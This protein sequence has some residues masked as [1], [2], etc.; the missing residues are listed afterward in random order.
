MADKKVTQLTQVTT[1]PDTAKIYAV[2]LTR[3]VDDQDVQIDKSDLVSGAVEGDRATITNVIPITNIAGSNYNFNTANP[4][5]AYTVTRNSI[6]NQFAQVFINTLTK[7]TLTLGGVTFTE[8]GGIGW[9]ASTDL[10]LYLRDLGV[11]GIHYAFLP[12]AVGSSGGGAVDSVNTQT[13]VVVLDTDDIADTAI[14]RYTNDTDI[15]RLANTS[16]TN[17]GD[18]TLS[19]TSDASSHTATLSASGGS[20]K[21]IE[22]TGITLTTAGTALDGTV[23]IDST[24]GGGGDVTK[25][26]TPLDNQIGVWTGD[27]TIEGDATLS[28]DGQ[29][30]RSSGTGGTVASNAGIVTN[31]LTVN[32][33]S[34]TAGGSASLFLDNNNGQVY[35]F[36]GDAGGSFGVWD[37]TANAARMSI[38]AAGA[39]NFNG[40]LTS[41]ASTVN[42]AISVTGT[43]DGRDI[44]A[45]GTRLAN[46]SG[47][48][49]GD[50]D[51]SAYLI[52]PT[53][54]AGDIIWRNAL[55]NIDRIGVG[56]ENDLLGISGGDVKWVNPPVNQ[57]LSNTSDVSS[58]TTTLSASGG[59]LKLIEGTGITLTT[60]GT[61]LDGTVTIDSTGGG[62][63]SGSITDNQVAIGATTADSIEG[64]ADMTYDSTT[65][66]LTLGTD[67]T[68]EDKAIIQAGTFS[69]SLNDGDGEFVAQG[70]FR[71][72]GFATF[73]G[74]GTDVLLDNGATKPILDFT[75]E[76]A[77]YSAT[78]TAIT[79]LDC[80]TFDSRYQILTANTDIQWTNTPASGE[81]FVKNLEVVST[82]TESLAFS[83]ATK[84]IGSFVSDGTTVNLITV[85]FA[86]YPTL[87]LRITVLI[88]Q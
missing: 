31:W 22:G 57:T 35:E 65:K 58:H 28:Y 87:G 84:I 6:I 15:T 46:T 36:Y 78:S 86:N 55:G 7:P 74:T 32:T 2:D 77:I 83:T 27:G 48:N 13:G 18:Q 59:S 72:G 11:D 41:G 49:T 71:G 30:L 16:G 25:V 79:T 67:G 26:G 4:E 24:G 42:G 3:A 76:T 68:A 64:S 39:V 82:A 20:V 56:A 51:L 81:S 75:S 54:T 12:K 33:A 61:A 88:T 47:L 40:T 8:V 53:T 1:L 38:T 5:T 29:T 37:K 63:I 9:T 45:D 52:D 14:N 62:T 50:Q 43:V 34:G 10:Y 69:V 80:D 17:T 60:A 21:L 19:N 73:G 44:A 85:N 70:D 23:T 66:T